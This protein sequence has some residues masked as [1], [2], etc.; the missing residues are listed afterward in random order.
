MGFASERYGV[1]CTGVTVSREQ[2][3]YGRKRYA[4]PA[5]TFRL[6]DYRQAADEPFD[7]IASMGMFEHVGPKNY[8]TYFETARRLLRED[9][10]FLLHTIWQ[11]ELSPL[12][13]WIDK[14]IFP[15]GALPTVG[16]IGTAVHGLFVVEDVHNFGPDYDK[17]LMAWNAKF[18]S[19]RAE[20]AAL[21]ARKGH[22]GERFCRMWEYYLLCC[23]GG[24]RSREISVGQFVLSPRGVREGYQSVR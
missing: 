21:M 7:R 9:G 11:N 6:Q 4:E 15:N 13:P 16:Q 2:V 5:V 17:T 8:R 3:E 14:Y 1:Q 24:F 10:L 23:A 22:D 12:D 18:Q 19:N 20:V